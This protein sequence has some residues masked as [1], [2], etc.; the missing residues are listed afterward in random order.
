MFLNSKSRKP[1]Q[2]TTTMGWFVVNRVQ[3]HYQLIPRFQNLQLEIIKTQ[4]L[5]DRISYN[6]QVTFCILTWVA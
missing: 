4:R 5:I 2:E 6:A 1:V 3:P